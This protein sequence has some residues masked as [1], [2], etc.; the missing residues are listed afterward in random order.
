MGPVFELLPLESEETMAVGEVLCVAPAV[1]A[2][3]VEVL[4]DPMSAPAGISGVSEKYG[5]ELST[6]TKWMIL[7]TSGP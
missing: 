5:F 4:E 7:T 1:A 6:K 2:V 3:R